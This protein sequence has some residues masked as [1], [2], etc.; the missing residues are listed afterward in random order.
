VFIFTLLFENSNL[1]IEELIKTSK[2]KGE[3]GIQNKLEFKIK[4]LTLFCQK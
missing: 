4:S 1:K 3:N 2:E